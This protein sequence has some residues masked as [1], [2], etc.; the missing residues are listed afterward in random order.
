[1]RLRLCRQSEMC[2]EE[3]DLLQYVRSD[4]MAI[5]VH[6]KEAEELEKGIH[7]LLKLIVC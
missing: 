7:D 6:Q 1:M 5:V 3:R 2:V 4:L